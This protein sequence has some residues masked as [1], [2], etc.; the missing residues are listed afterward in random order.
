MKR[1]KQSRG[2]W[3]D[4]RTL[5]RDRAVQLL[6]IAQAALYDNKPAIAMVN[7]GVALLTMARLDTKQEALAI[8]KQIRRNARKAK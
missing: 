3:V 2:L 1:E 5:D 7:A 4:R 6:T 8:V